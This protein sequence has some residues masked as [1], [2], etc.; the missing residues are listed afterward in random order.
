MANEQAREELKKLRELNIRINALI[1]DKEE[2]LERVASLARPLSEPVSGTRRSDIA[3]AAVKL[4]DMDA[5][6]C[7]TIDDCSEREKR[8][9]AR[10]DA[11]SDSRYR[12]LLSL[13]YTN[14]NP[15]KLHQV[16]KI[17]HY[18]YSTIKVMHV[19]ALAMYQ[20]KYFPP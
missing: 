7:R 6:I 12:T 3:N 4:A 2:L 17:M 10:I 1:E 14:K 16:A 19:C 8:I 11:I 13:Y 20:R 15:L 5:E 18:Q 9:K